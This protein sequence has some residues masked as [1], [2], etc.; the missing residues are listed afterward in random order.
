VLV[1]RDGQLRFLGALL[2]HAVTLART[3]EASQQAVLVDH[4]LTDAVALV[5]LLRDLGVAVR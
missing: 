3:I 4:P 5:G 2:P 1:A